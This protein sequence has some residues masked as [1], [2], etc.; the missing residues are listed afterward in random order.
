MDTPI[1]LFNFHSKLDVAEAA[2]GSLDEV[3]KINI[4]LTDLDDFPVVNEVMGRFFKKP[5]PARSTGEQ[6]AL[7]SRS[8]D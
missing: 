4:F 3:V 2:G 5:Y 8:F 6:R 7:I 1:D